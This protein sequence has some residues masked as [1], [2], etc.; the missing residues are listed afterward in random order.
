MAVVG[1][2]SLLVVAVAACVSDDPGPRTLPDAGDGCGTY[3]D[4]IIGKCTGQNRAFDNREQCM[5]MCALMPPGQ[6][7]DKT[8]S[9]ACRAAAAKTASDKGT[10]ANAGAY[11]NGACGDRCDTFCELVNK[12]CIEPFGGQAPAPYANKADCVEA[13]RTMRYDAAD[14]EGPG[15]TDG[16]DTL[17]CRM[18]HLILSLDGRE[19]H[20]PHVAVPSATCQSGGGGGDAGHGDHDGGE[21]AGGRD[22]G[23]APGSDAGD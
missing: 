14:F 4:D 15:A 3:C 13:C 18:L 21:D 7:N 20:C 10:C 11:G 5:K 6:E 9:V 16:V 2:V 12:Q 17:N 19:T 8:N 1:S 23:G 22:A